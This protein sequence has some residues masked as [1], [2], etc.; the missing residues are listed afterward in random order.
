MIHERHQKFNC[1]NKN[2]E[3]SWIN[4]TI[5]K[6]VLE[7]IIQALFGTKQQIITIKK[8]KKKKNNSTNTQIIMVENV[9]DDYSAALNQLVKPTNENDNNINGNVNTNMSVIFQPEV[10]SQN[11]ATNINTNSSNNN[12]NS[13]TTSIAAT[14]AGANGNDIN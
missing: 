3:R 11:V 1:Q 5:S 7:T 13:K 8:T 12:S 14:Q 9:S 2:K 10:N 4:S 6:Q